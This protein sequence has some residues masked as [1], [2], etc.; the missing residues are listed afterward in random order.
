MGCIL[1]NKIFPPRYGNSN[2]LTMWGTFASPPYDSSLL[3]LKCVIFW[4]FSEKQRQLVFSN[5]YEQAVGLANTCKDCGTIKTVLVCLNTL[6]SQHSN[7]SST[8]GVSLGAWLSV[9]LTNGR[10]LFEN[11][12]YFSHHWVQKLHTS[13]FK[14]KKH[15]HTHKQ[16]HTHTLSSQHVAFK[17][18]AWYFSLCISV[19][20]SAELKISHKLRRPTHYSMH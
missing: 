19:L 17:H 8:N 1:A 9:C 18:W 16:T 2:K 3:K 7:I 6:T 11:N 4:L 12:H 14:L 5:K 20:N 10:N 13:A 15:I